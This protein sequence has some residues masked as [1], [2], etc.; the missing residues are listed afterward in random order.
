MNSTSQNR[1]IDT[2]IKLIINFHFRDKIKNQYF[3]ENIIFA[4]IVSDKYF[5]LTFKIYV[6]EYGCNA[7]DN[8]VHKIYAWSITRVDLQS[9]FY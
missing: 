4:Q 6:P 2:Y 7:S 3:H 8:C 5:N 1:C 9:P